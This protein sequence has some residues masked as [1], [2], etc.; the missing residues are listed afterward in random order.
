VIERDADSIASTK[1]GYKFKIVLARPLPDGLAEIVGDAVTNLR[2]ALDHCMSAAHFAAFG[3]SVKACYF[4]IAGSASEFE[5]ALKGRCKVTELY[6]LLR[7][8]Q[9]YKGGNDVLWALSTIANR[10]KHNARLFNPM[11]TTA[12]I[13]ASISGH[14]FQFLDQATWDGSKD[15]IVFLT[16]REDAQF[17]HDF[18]ISVFVSFYDIP[19][20]DAGPVPLVLDAMARIVEGALIAIEAETRR[21]FPN[22]F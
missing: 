10:D 22:A 18:Q 11:Q 4:P 8:F 17:Y 3:R 19:V 2:D 13:K 20:V 15:E 16:A 12:A 1:S 14:G 6:A 21:L 9:P 5:N 7:T